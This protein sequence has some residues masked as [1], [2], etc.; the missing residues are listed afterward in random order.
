MPP[1]RAKE[2]LRALVDTLRPPDLVREGL[3]TALRRRIELLRRA[4]LA[5]GGRADHTV[6]MI[7]ATRRPVL[8]F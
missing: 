4:T 5:L 8:R 1:H 2:E 6:S 7:S 3:A